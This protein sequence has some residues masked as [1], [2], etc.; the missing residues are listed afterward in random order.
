MINRRLSRRSPSGAPPNSFAVQLPRSRPSAG[1]KASAGAGATPKTA[2]QSLRSGRIHTALTDRRSCPGRANRPRPMVSPTRSQPAAA[3]TV[4]AWVS[5]STKVSTRRGRSPY[6]ASISPGSRASALPSTREPRF[7]P[8]TDG[9]IRNRLRPI[10]AGFR[11]C[12]RR[13]SSHPIHRSRE[14]R[15][16]AGAEQPRAPRMP[17]SDRTRYRSGAPTCIAAPHGCSR[18]LSSFQIRRSASPVTGTRRRSC[19]APASGGTADAT[20]TPAPSRRRAP[21]P[22][23]RWG[24]GNCTCRVGSRSSNTAW[25]LRSR[26]RPRASI[27]RNSRH[28]RRTPARRRAGGSRDRSACSRRRCAGCLKMRCTGSMADRSRI[29]EGPCTPVKPTDVSHRQP[30]GPPEVQ[31]SP[32]AMRGRAGSGGP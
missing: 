26:Q 22:R 31:R 18:N 32:I 7:R 1:P 20:G 13:V 4:P 23:P 25:Q 19:S 5:G 2:R 21:P 10:T 14:A 24:G 16:K 8:R 3:Y 9:R 15:R 29:V 27:R 30:A 6:R 11:C 12:D 17:C 28:T